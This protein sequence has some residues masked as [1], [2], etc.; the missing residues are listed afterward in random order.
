MCWF[1]ASRPWAAAG[2]CVVAFTLFTSSAR[3]VGLEDLGQYLGTWVNDTFYDPNFP[4]NATGPVDITLAVSDSTLHVAFDLG[5]L[6]FGFADPP[7]I[8]FDAPLTFDGGGLVFPVNFS[9]AQAQ[10]MLGDISG[11][12]ESDGSLQLVIDNLLAPI[13]NLGFTRLEAAGTLDGGLLE[14][15][16]DVFKTTRANEP[17]ASGSLTAV[18]IP[19]PATAALLLVCGGALLRRSRRR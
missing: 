14:L 18:L 8:L 12:L 10:T 3:A 11:T 4:N 1:G 5:G 6:I 9:A 2:A 19:E 7:P 13:A 17:Y 16:Y 15:A